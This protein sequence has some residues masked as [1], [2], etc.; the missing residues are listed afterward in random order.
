MTVPCRQ[1]VSLA[2]GQTS[3]D[4]TFAYVAEQGIVS[5]VYGHNGS[6]YF[7]S[8]KRHWEFFYVDS[9]ELEW[10]PSNLV[11]TFGSTTSNFT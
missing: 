7:A 11:G 3:Q 1:V 10:C 4:L 2:F 9:M 5:N 6:T 8:E